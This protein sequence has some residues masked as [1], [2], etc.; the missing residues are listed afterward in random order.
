M[1]LSDSAMR[2]DV[3]DW[4]HIDPRLTNEFDN[5]KSSY[6]D[7]ISWSYAD[8]RDFTQSDEEFFKLIGS[9]HDKWM[10]TVLDM[11]LLYISSTN[12]IIK[13]VAL[14][15][16][17]SPYYERFDFVDTQYKH[18]YQSCNLSFFYNT[19]DYPW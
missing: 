18:D 10:R 13:D 11:S 16:K 14:H 17:Q 2:Y 6:W 3:K 7:F 15:W 19:K 1:W 5:T 12:Y 8:T 4:R 9:F